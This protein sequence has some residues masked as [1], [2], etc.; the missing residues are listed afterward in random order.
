[1]KNKNLLFTVLMFCLCFLANSQTKLNQIAPMNPVALKFTV[2]DYELKGPVKQADKMF[3]DK[4]GRITKTDEDGEQTYTYKPTAI[5][6]N[7]YGFT[8]VY[9]LNT[10]KQV[11]AWNIIGEKDFG[12]FKYDPK[13]NL[14]EQ[15]SLSDG[16]K[17]KT[18]Y[19]Y[20]AQNRLIELSEWSD[21][22]PYITTY[23]YDG[24]PDNLSVT[25]IV[26]GDSSSKTIYYYKKG[27]LDNY[28]QMGVLQR[29]DVKYDARGN[30]MSFY[31]P[32][33]GSNQQRFVD[34]Y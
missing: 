31:N 1:M 29:Q 16:F 14:V 10:A 27:I 9:K 30:W 23:S 7:K 32:V 4:L 22:I 18:T 21:A 25:T 34:Y 3:F 24:T 2:F 33:Y 19:K 15:S 28:K 13:G 20:D 5:E 8:Y 6:V 26:G 11:V 12:D 17:S